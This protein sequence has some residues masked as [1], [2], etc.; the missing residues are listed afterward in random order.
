[1]GILIGIITSLI[2]IVLFLLNDK[3]LTKNKIISIVFALILGAIGS[4]ICYRLEMHYGGLITVS[5]L[6]GRKK[7]SIPSQH[8]C[9]LLFTAVM[10]KTSIPI[11]IC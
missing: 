7:S 6:K 1:M 9:I 4:Y 11:R 3:S 8:R 10:M 5:I 2:L